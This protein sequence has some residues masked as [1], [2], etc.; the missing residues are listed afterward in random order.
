MG[1]KALVAALADGGELVA[2]LGEALPGDRYD[3]LL[4]EMLLE[5]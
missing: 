4:G 1:S 5:P 2:D 3:A